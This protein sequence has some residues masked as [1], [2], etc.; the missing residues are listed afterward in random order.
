MILCPSVQKGSGILVVP[1]ENIEGH[2][3]PIFTY[4]EEGGSA[5][6]VRL[7]HMVSVSSLS[8]KSL[9]VMVCVHI[10]S[11]ASWHFSIPIFKNTSHTKCPQQAVRGKWENGSE[12][13]KS[14]GNW[15]SPVRTLCSCQ[16]NLIF[17]S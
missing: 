2:C 10:R 8:K 17:K 5:Y 9:E 1:D 4:L 6:F 12:R 13:K 15:A 3:V 7:Q 14:K 16:M 11:V